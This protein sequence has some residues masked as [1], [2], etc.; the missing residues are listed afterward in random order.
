MVYERKIRFGNKRNSTWDV[1][2][3]KSVAIVYASEGTGHKSAAFALREY[4]AAHNPESNV[5]CLDILD[6]VPKAVKNFVSDGYVSL[7]RNTPFIWGWLYNSSNKESWN[8]KLFTKIHNALCLKFLSALEK[9][10]DKMNVDAVFFTHYFGAE[11]LAKRNRNKY[12]VFFV[13]TD[14]ISHK[15]Q[16]SKYFTHTFVASLDDKALYEENGITDVTVSGIPI[17]LKY[18]CPPDK[19]SAR[20][21]LGINP[22]ERVIM[23]SGGGI[24]AGSIYEIAVNFDE[25][26]EENT[27]ILVICGTHEEL[28]RKLKKKIRNPKVRI[29][30]FVRDIQLFYAASDLAIIK[31]GGLSVSECLATKV[32][33]LFVDPIPGQETWNQKTICSAGAAMEVLV[34]ENAAH[35]AQDLIKDPFFLKYLKGNMEK[36]SCPDASQTITAKAEEIIK[37][38]YTGKEE[39]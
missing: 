16:R 30:E 20:E 21:Q 15:F 32:P 35:F 26:L 7:A 27:T 8:A 4:L 31:P 39:K 24:G 29:F 19:S 17:S 5:V 1:R 10:L 23:I 11:L 2:P 34:S 33:M 22:D 13:N 37:E 18:S 3:L 25:N 6:F 36:I 14:F 28:Y 12:P 38:H 9:R